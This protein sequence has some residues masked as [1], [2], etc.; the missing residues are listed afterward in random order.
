M[1]GF[2]RSD[3]PQGLFL[4]EEIGVDEGQAATLQ[5]Y[6]FYTN[7]YNLIETL[8]TGLLKPRAG[9]QKYYKDLLDLCPGYLPLFWRPQPSGVHSYGGTDS[10]A[11]PVALEIDPERLAATIGAMPRPNEPAPVGA[12]GNVDII[13]VRGV[14]PLS[15]VRTIHFRS[16]TERKEH[17]ARRYTNVPEQVPKNLVSPHIFG[18]ED[19]SQ[20]SDV[21]N[22]ISSLPDLDEPSANDFTDA[23]SIAGGIA[24][25]SHFAPDPVGFASRIVQSVEAVQPLSTDSGFA[26]LERIIVS[27]IAENEAITGPDPDERLFIAIARAI[28]YEPR[29]SWRPVQFLRAL[30]D[31][32]GGPDVPETSPPTIGKYIEKIIGIAEGFEEVPPFTGKGLISARGLLLYSLGAEPTAVDRWPMSIA[33]PDEL[34]CA[35]GAFFVGLRSG[36]ARLSTERRPQDIDRVLLRWECEWLN[37]GSGLVTVVPHQFKS[38]TRDSHVNMDKRVD[39][40]LGSAIHVAEAF[41]ANENGGER[42]RKLA[43]RI[44]DEMKWDDC[45]VTRVYG[46]LAPVKEGTDKAVAFVG[47]PKIITRINYKRLMERLHVERLPR[48]LLDAITPALDHVLIRKAAEDPSSNQ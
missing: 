15:A 34:S 39:P 41:R 12:R 13:I 9:Y 8:S 1:T 22:E 36:R 24:L 47:R 38:V 6:W 45:A 26:W 32:V 3:Q 16:E 44:I 28:R 40:E 17:Q 7:R 43:F 2:P 29:D 19:A 5:A 11:F 23:S 10:T 18:S 31:K 14:I 4:T 48:S 25:A 35:A 33:H 42:V 46:S 27:I 37:R 21:L 20:S 30:L